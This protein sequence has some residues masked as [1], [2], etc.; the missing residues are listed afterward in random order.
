MSTSIRKR[1]RLATLASALTVGLWTSTASAVGPRDYAG[2][3][4]LEGSVGSPKPE[5]PSRPPAA[6][7]RRGAGPRDYEGPDTIAPSQPPSGSP[8]S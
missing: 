5:T 1:T 6:R 2:P 3:E 8:P 7:E 4:D